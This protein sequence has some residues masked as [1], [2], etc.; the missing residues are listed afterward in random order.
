MSAEQLKPLTEFIPAK[1]I[2]D[3][4]RGLRN[5]RDELELQPGP[6]H[7]LTNNPGK[8]M[9]PFLHMG[10]TARQTGFYSLRWLAV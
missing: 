2:N 6:G 9:N 5:R 3:Q 1:W 10:K 8:V 4:R 7:S